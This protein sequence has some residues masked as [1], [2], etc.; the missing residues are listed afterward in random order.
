MK[1]LLTIFLAIICGVVYNIPRDDEAQV[2]GMHWTTITNT[3]EQVTKHYGSWYTAPKQ[4]RNV[5]CVFKQHGTER[6]YCD[7]KGNHCNKCPVFDSWCEYNVDEWTLL[8]MVIQEAPDYNPTWPDVYV[9]GPKQKSIAEI[10][11]EVVFKTR[12][13]K[14][15]YKPD[16]LYNY[17]RFQVGAMWKIKRE[18]AGTLKP[19]KPTG[20]C[21]EVQP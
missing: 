7:I 10:K 20:G 1:I 18:K 8:E 19:L 12:S 11:F 15:V 21:S 3:Y 14:L 17:Q 5:K 2:V 4:A 13:E 9:A 16:N 6:C